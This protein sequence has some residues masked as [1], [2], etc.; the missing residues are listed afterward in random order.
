MVSLSGL[1]WAA[2]TPAA[3][4]GRPESQTGAAVAHTGG[5][6]PGPDAVSPASAVDSQGI[7]G[8]WVA[9]CVRPTSGCME[10][11]EV[12]AEPGA[13]TAEG[14]RG[15]LRGGLLAAQE[16][17]GPGPEDGKGRV[18]QSQLPPPSAGTD[19]GRQGLWREGQ[20]RQNP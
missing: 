2:A 3:I 16:G 7:V 12:S 17:G 15:V 9:G 19:W 8:K 11:A 4:P 18:S 1:G 10:A 14:W 20:R 5:T 13:P 6:D